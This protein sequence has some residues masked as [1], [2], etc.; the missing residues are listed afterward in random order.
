MKHATVACTQA[1]TASRLVKIGGKWG[2]ACMVHGANKETY[3]TLA[4]ENVEFV[5]IF[6]V[7]FVMAAWGGKYRTCIRKQVFRRHN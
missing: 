3:F 2:V 7:W 5:G 4:R 6:G 1:E